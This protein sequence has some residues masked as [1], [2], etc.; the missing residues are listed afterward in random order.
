MQDTVRIH[1]SILRDIQIDIMINDRQAD[2]RGEGKLSYDEMST[3]MKE[4]M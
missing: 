1:E 3:N 2:R 4:I